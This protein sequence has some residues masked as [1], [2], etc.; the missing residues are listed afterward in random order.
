M[1]SETTFPGYVQRNAVAYAMTEG[2]DP[3]LGKP[4]DG[5]V[6]ADMPDGRVYDLIIKRHGCSPW[7][8][9]FSGKRRR[10]H[11]RGLNRL[12]KGKPY[13]TDGQERALRRFYDG[14]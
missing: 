6:L 9:V 4:P 13:L 10:R 12:R 1:A 11:K 8:N 3:V 14:A 2:D 7:N 5:A